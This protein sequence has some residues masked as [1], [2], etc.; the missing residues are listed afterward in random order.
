MPLDKSS[1]ILEDI[2]S[3]A[4]SVGQVLTKKS[5]T[6]TFDIENKEDKIDFVI[7][8]FANFLKNHFN[9]N[10]KYYAIIDKELK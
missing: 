6:G 10:S 9:D 4:V 7:E 1:S 8:R 5:R 3:D 2:F